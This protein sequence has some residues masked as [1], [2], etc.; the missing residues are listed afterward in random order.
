MSDRPRGEIQVL[1]SIGVL[2][3]RFPVMTLHS[4]PTDCTAS[5]RYAPM[6]TCETLLKI[7]VKSRSSQ[8]KQHPPGRYRDGLEQTWTTAGSFQSTILSV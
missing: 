5:K 3:F 2:N 6:P 8:T 1:T 7:T 4:Y